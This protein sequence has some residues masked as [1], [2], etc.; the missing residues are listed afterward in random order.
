MKKT[1]TKTQENNE[2]IP[3]ETKVAY[4]IKSLAPLLYKGAV[5][6]PLVRCSECFRRIAG[7]DDYCRGCGTRLVGRPVW[8][9]DVK[10]EE[11]RLI[12]ED[13]QKEFAEKMERKAAEKKPDTD[14]TNDCITEEEDPLW[15]RMEEMLHFYDD[16]AIKQAESVTSP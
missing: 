16:A 13:L 5:L 11:K 2:A 10:K 14:A 3:A 9:E 8:P 12:V 7:D 6:A 15:K 4:K 1:E